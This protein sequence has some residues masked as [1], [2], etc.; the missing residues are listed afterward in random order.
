MDPRSIDPMCTPS[1]YL[2]SIIYIFSILKWNVVAPNGWVDLASDFRSD[3]P[4]EDSGFDSPW[5]PPLFYC[6]E[7]FVEAF[8]GEDRT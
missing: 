7:N 5:A 6:S 4:D 3:E 1:F 8:C 2:K